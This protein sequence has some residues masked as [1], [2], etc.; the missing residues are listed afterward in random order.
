MSY[1]EFGNT[2]GLVELPYAPEKGVIS[3]DYLH[4]PVLRQDYL[5]KWYESVKLG[6]KLILPYHYISNTDYPVDKIEEWI[7]VNIQL[8]DESSK[9][10]DTNK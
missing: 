4:N 10:V 1:F 8:V 9:I 2:K 3:L 5:Q 6:K 7:K